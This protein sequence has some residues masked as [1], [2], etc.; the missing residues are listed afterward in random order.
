[1]IKCEE[2]EEFQISMIDNGALKLKMALSREVIYGKALSSFISEGSLMLSATPASTSTNWFFSAKLAIGNKSL[3]MLQEFR[4]VYFGDVSNEDLKIQYT[5]IASGDYYRLQTGNKKLIRMFIDKLESYPGI[6]SLNVFEN[7][8]KD[9][10]YYLWRKGFLLI[11]NDPITT[12]AKLSSFLGLRAALRA[13][14]AQNSS[15]WTDEDILEGKESKTSNDTKIKKGKCKTFKE[16][17]EL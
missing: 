11:E 5:P 15:I 2:Y 6:D 16:Q 13:N 4:Q 9:N 12:Y 17:K 8:I 14:R 7:D 1:M 10:E 3:S